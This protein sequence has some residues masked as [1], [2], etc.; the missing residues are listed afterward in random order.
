MNIALHHASKPKDYYGL[1]LAAM[2]IVLM[3]ILSSSSYYLFQNYFSNTFLTYALSGKKVYFLHS[4]TLKNMYEKNGMDYDG[5]QKRLK[6]FK[7]LCL[8][9]TY[10]AVNVSSDGIDTLPKH[11]ILVALDMMSLS[12]DEVEDLDKFVS[13]GGRLLF[14]FTSGFLDASLHYRANNLVKRVT[15]LTLDKNIN[16]I[17]QNQKD[18]GYMA[19]KLLSP[20]SKYLPAGKSMEFIVYDPLPIFNT[21]LE[22]ESYMTTWGL[23]NYIKINKSKSLTKEQSGLIWKGAKSLGKWVYFSFP[24]Y[25]FV[26]NDAVAYAKIFKGILDY[27]DKDMTAIMYPYIDAKNVMFISEDT[28]YKFTNLENFYKVSLKNKF[29]VT[30]FCVANLAQ[31]YP[32]LMKKVITSPY[33]EIGSHSYTHKKIVGESDAVIKRE[34]EGANKLLHSLTGRD[35]IGFRPPRE[36]LNKEMITDLQDSG[37]KYILSESKSRLYP[38]GYMN[39]K[40]LMI[41]RHGTDDYSY[42]INLDWNSSQILQQIKTEA[43]ILADLNGMYTLSTH[44]HLMSFSTN[45]NITDKFMQYVNKQKRLTAMNG[46]M[47]YKRVI[48]RDKIHLSTKQTNKKFIMTF[49]NDSNEKV[50]DVHYELSVSPDIKLGRV[51][52]EVIGVQTK[53]IKNKSNTYTLIIKSMSPK[54]QMILFVN[55]EKNS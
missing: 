46:A 6:H 50:H 48:L 7:Q 14:N 12:H 35:I 3:L 22:A 4:D 1:R 29:P 44:T 49:S 45:I 53:L 47:I 28:E 43:N 10:E 32:E 25:V 5:Y 15:T 27:L 40:M 16:T 26:D 54:S 17:K 8:E 23:D 37:T 24:S 18:G 52:S 51:E 33:M 13:G 39:G 34:T 2:L 42:L 21:K 31:K 38:F 30:A 19:T 36:E 11:A 55:Y 41:P 20:L 9:D